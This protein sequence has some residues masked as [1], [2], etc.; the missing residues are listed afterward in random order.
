MANRGGQPGNNNNQRG[1]LWND[2]LRKAI[3]Q[4]DG[5]RLRLAAEQL[6]DK[7][8]DGEAWA[9]KE[10]ADRLDGKAFQSVEVSGNEGG[11][12]VLQLTNADASL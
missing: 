11:A 12:I 9:I 2:A 5:R 10:L 3:V 1:K 4:E 6:L 7:A 8:A